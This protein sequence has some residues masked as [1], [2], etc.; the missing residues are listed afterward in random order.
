[1]INFV[2]N[3]LRLVL[4]LFGL[5]GVMVLPD[6]LGDAGVSVTFKVAVAA[7]VVA[8]VVVAMFGKLESKG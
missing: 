6:L 1:M 2:F 4:L 5:N 8:S 3:A 7:L